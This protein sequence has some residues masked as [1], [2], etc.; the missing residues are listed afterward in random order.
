[1]ATK[2]KPTPKPA[3]KPAPKATSP[4]KLHNLAARPSFTDMLDEQLVDQSGVF[5][6]TSAIAQ[7]QTGHEEDDGIFPGASGSLPIARGGEDFRDDGPTLE[8]PL[9]DRIIQDEAADA[10][11]RARLATLAARAKARN[12]TR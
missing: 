4:G 10:E 8:D 9:A 6:V 12:R 5:R 3:S 7:A 2:K 11:K 1:M